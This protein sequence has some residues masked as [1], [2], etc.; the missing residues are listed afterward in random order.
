MDKNVFDSIANNA[1]LKVKN[2]YEKEIDIDVSAISSDE[3]FFKYVKEIVN[4]VRA[5]NERYTDELA[6]GIIS[7]YENKK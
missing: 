6:K 5:H 4:V 1:Y 2:Q 7:F 3:D